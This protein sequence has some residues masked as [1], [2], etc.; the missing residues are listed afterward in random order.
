MKGFYNGKTKEGIILEVVTNHKVTDF[1]R[2]LQLYFQ[3]KIN[4]MVVTNHKVTDF[5]RILQ[6][7]FSRLKRSGRCN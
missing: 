2:I 7:L 4:R 3:T 5:E 6:H 1:E